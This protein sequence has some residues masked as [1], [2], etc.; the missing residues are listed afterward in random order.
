MRG[1][2]AEKRDEPVS[3]K[4][5]DVAVVLLD[6]ARDNRQHVVGEVAQ[7]LGVEVAGERAEPGEVEKHR[8]HPTPL[9]PRRGGCKRR[10]A[11]PAKAHRRRVVRGTV[12][13]VYT[14]MLTIHK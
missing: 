10:S 5:V 9:A 13:A 7:A 14:H 11:H 6:D 2:R 8:R 4:G 12:R 1:R 3:L